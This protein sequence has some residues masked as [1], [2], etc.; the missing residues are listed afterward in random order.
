MIEFD[1]KGF[2]EMINTLDNMGKAGEN[3]FKKALDEGAKPV[4]NAMKRKVYQ[5][6]HRRTGEL[7]D[8]IKIGKV[9]KLRDGTYSQVIGILKGDISSV[10]Y[11]KFSE[12]G[13]SH[14]PA[15]PWQRPAFDESKDKAY[16]KIEQELTNGIDNAFKK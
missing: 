16:A 12:Y 1:T 11:G 9:R 6:L 8:N 2:Q 15:R 4:L 3:I 5:V 10:Y 14:E 13:S 7:Q